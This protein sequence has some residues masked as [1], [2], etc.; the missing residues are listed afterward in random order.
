MGIKG[1]R[2]L[3]TPDNLLPQRP[4]AWMELTMLLNYARCGSKERILPRAGNET[5]I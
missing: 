2:Q 4:R 3:H 5:L 1:K